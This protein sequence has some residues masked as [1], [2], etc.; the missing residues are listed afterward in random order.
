MQIYI[1]DGAL[2]ENWSDFKLLGKI[3][4]HLAKF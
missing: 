3:G 1:C 4:E 2:H